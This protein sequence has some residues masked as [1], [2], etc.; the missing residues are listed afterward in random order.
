MTAQLAQP[1]RRRADPIA[2]ARLFERALQLDLLN[3]VL[4]EGPSFSREDFWRDAL[5]RGVGLLTAVGEARE[6]SAV[7]SA[8]W[9]PTI[10]MVGPTAA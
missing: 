1:P 10:E 3:W 2:R 4:G 5:P 6:L 9:R 8:A 7:L